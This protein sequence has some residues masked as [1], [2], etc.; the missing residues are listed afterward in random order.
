MNSFY[1]LSCALKGIEEAISTQRHLRIHIAVAG[2][3]VAFGLLLGLPYIDLVLL[4]VVITLVVVTELLNTAVELTV[5]LISPAFHPIAGRIKDIAA[6]AV[7][8][9][10]TVAAAVGIVILAPPLFRA[11]V[12][13]PFSAKSVML[14]ATALGLMGSIVVALLPHPPRRQAS[15]VERRVDE[16]NTGHVRSH[17]LHPIPHTH[18]SKHASQR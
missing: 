13:T 17:T 4:L 11:L 8:I 3:V 12:A 9:A 16:G 5:D 15:S 6:G 10:A 1:P 18:N 2:L 7:L 14:A